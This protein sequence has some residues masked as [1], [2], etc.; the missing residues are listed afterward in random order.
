MMVK[1]RMQRL[2]P[3]SLGGGEV[4]SPQSSPGMYTDMPLG[5][6][7]DLLLDHVLNGPLKPKTDSMKCCNA[8]M[9]VSFWD[10]DYTSTVTLSQCARLSQ[11]RAC[12]DTHTR[13]N[14]SVFMCFIFNLKERTTR[15]LG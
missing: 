4:S 8:L 5:G 15:L 10:Y 7:R 14:A 6:D 12:I 2:W 1:K 11:N 13:L 9:T 3:R